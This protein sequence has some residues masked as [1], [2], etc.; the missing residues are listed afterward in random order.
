MVDCDGTCS[1]N[2]TAG[3]S[4]N[5]PGK[6]MADGT[7]QGQCD[8]KCTMRAGATVKCNGTCTGKC[9]GS[10][11][12]AANAMAKCDA[13]CKG[14]CSV[15]VT[16][17]KCDAELKAVPPMCQA[18]ANCN[19]NCAA[20][21][22]AR[23]ECT[24]PSVTIVAKGMVTVQDQFDAVVNTLQVHVPKLAVAFQGRG[25]AFVDAFSGAAKAGLS[26]AGDAPKLGAK[27]TA[28]ATV[29]ANAA[30]TGSANMTTAFQASGNVIGELGK[31]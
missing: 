25:Q 18:D 16:A 13:S 2:C 27:G 24:D 15:A 11:K 23:A 29:I 21:G 10:C 12:F 17:P 8:G 22:S 5:G 30:A 9:T 3:G 7:C 28:C 1:G 14:G 19:A 4:L 6:N 26:I 20:S 31:L